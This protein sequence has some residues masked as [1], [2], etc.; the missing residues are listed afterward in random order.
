MRTI[1]IFN[2]FN[3][4]Y[5]M[6][7][8]VLEHCRRTGDKLVIYTSFDN[9]L[10]W[11]N[12]YRK[13]FNFDDFR[14]TTSFEPECHIYDAI[15]LTTDDDY[16]FI[17][18]WFTLYDIK[19][20]IIKINHTLYQR[21]PEI[22]LS[23]DIR[24]Y[25][26]KPERTHIVPYFQYK[27]QN[28]T[29]N[30]KLKFFLTPGFSSRYNLEII[31]K[32]KDYDWVCVG[33]RIDPIIRQILPNAKFIKNGDIYTVLEEMASSDFIFFCLNPKSDLVNISTSGFIGLAFS[34][35]TNILIDEISD[36]QYKFTSSVVYNGSIPQPN[37]SL[38]F[39]E[40]Q[41]WDTAL[42]DFLDQHLP[43]PKISEDMIIPKKIHFMWLGQKPFPEKYK[44]NISRYI[45]LN[46]NFEIKIWNDHTVAELYSRYPEYKKTFDSFP[47]L[48]NKCDFTRFLIIYLE[49]GLYS[50]LDF[51]CRK[52][53]SGL[54]KNQEYYIVEEIPEHEDSKK[55]YN[56]FFAAIPRHPFIKGWLDKMSVNVK[57]IPKNSHNYVMH[58]TGPFG[59]YKYLSENNFSV[60]PQDPCPVI[61][62][63]RDGKQSVICK[64]ETPLYAYTL[65][66]EGTDWGDGGF[67]SF[68]IKYLYFFIFIIF[69]I[70][71]VSIALVSRNR[72]YKSSILVN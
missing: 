33:R 47:R 63:T 49:G 61:P 7:G 62:Y 28:T 58:T 16:N 36:K 41:K 2:G 53:L 50:D 25:S 44:K 68:L 42:E 30:K 54:L 1:A 52:E 22:K 6:F 40:R 71:I 60:T 66:V 39:S 56:G 24:P 51:Y 45:D 14:P 70:L 67:I 34:C 55:L 57:T 46:P 32:L 3:F 64:D 5:E 12:L 21:R 69:T 17:S 48:I 43:V 4:H 38:V 27:T 13:E 23:I 19:D 26:I 8:F 29:V 65:W 37:R 15:I 9:D 31:E 72:T 20:K 11:F 18:R 59:F 10:G 35:G